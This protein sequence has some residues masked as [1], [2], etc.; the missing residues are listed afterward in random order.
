MLANWTCGQLPYV[1]TIIHI[2]ITYHSKNKSI[3]NHRVLIDVST[4]N[5]LV[6]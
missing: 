6:G 1:R 5:T 4:W 2:I 3:G